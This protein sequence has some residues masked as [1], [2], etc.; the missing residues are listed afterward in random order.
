MRPVNTERR[1]ALADAAIEVLAEAGIRGLTHRA[2][3][4]AAGT[5]DGTASRYFRTR[6]AMLIAVVDRIRG[7]RIEALSKLEALVV[8][9]EGLV[10]ALV[11]EVRDSRTK[12]RTRQ[13]AITALFLESSHR[14]ALRDELALVAQA[15]LETLE[16]LC[17]RAGIELAQ[18]DAWA[19]LTFFNGA[20]F[21]G[22][23][24][25]QLE[26]PSDATVR[27][28]LTSLLGPYAGSARRG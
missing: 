9:R 3:D 17:A 13:L 8:D 16:R 14:P 2:V 18:P 10:D 1:A 25:P 5:P 22:L 20:I 28:G 24:M 27:A 15:L 21:I 26:Q 4:A 23:T 12:D 19:L 6:E 7:L 11:A